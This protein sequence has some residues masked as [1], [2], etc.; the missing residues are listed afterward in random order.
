[1]LKEKCKNYIDEIDEMTRKYYKILSK[2]FPEFL[3]EYIYTEEMQRLDGINQIC[4]AYW[5]KPNAFEDIYSVLKHSVAVALIVWNFT[6]DK[7]QTLSA[8]F[9]DIS[10]PAFKHL[11]DFVNGDSEKQESLE[12]NTENIIRASKKIME[13]LK[14]DKIDIDKISDY[15]IYPIADNDTPRLSADRLEYTF[16]NGVYYINA[17]TL[18]EIKEIYDNIIIA[19]N[20]DGVQ[21]LAF[22]DIEIAE[23][24]VEVASKL[25]PLWIRAE[26]TITVYAFARIIEKMYK[27]NYMSVEDL[28]NLSEK[29]IINLVKAS[30]DKEISDLF[31]SFMNINEFFETDEETKDKF[32]VSRKVKRR[33]INPLV[34]NKRVYDISKKAKENIDGYFNIKMTKYAYIDW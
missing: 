22:E 20:E 7:I 6:H 32:C 17:W 24:F 11:L 9:H 14:R 34:N 15:K 3:N 4:G 19:E 27:A 25:W 16:M 12:D 28:Y 1:M 13:L 26:D 8:L 21:E 29:Q 33:Y 23:K 30:K 18:D 10:S 2:D 31:I 5:K